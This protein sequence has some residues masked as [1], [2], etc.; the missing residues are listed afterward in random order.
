MKKW[1][2]G[3]GGFLLIVISLFVIIVTTIFSP[4]LGGFGGGA[5]GEGSWSGW[6]ITSPFGERVHPITGVVKR[7]NGVD[8]AVPEGTPLPSFTDGV[9]TETGYDEGGYGYYI[10]VRNADGSETLYGHLSSIGVEKGQTVSRGQQIGN[11]GNTGGSTGPHLHLE[12]RDAN[13]NL[14]DPTQVL[15]PF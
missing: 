7:H 12:Y 10:V 11:T 1:V 13:G 5:T 2:I 8:L 4:L 9:V 3:M 15:K 14:Q 6:E